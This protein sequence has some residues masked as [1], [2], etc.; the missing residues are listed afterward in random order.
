MMRSLENDILELKRFHLESNILKDTLNTCV[1]RSILPS[2]PNEKFVHFLVKLELLNPGWG[3]TTDV[4]RSRDNIQTLVKHLVNVLESQ[5]LLPVIALKMQFYYG[6]S[7]QHLDSSIS[8]N[9]ERMAVL[10]RP[11]RNDI[12]SVSAR[13]AFYNPDLFD[14]K[15]ISYAVLLTGIGNPQESNVYCEALRVWRSVMDEK[16]FASFLQ[17]DKEERDQ[18][19]EEISYLICGIRLYNWHSGKSEGH[20]IRDYGSLITELIEILRRN[21]ENTI[22]GTLKWIDVLAVTVD[23][24]F[25]VSCIGDEV[26]LTL[27]LS[28]DIKKKDVYA[29]RDLLLIF[30]QHL[31][32]LRKMLHLLKTKERQADQ[33]ARTFQEKLNH[34]DGMIVGRYAVVASET[35][36]VFIDLAKSW[37]DLKNR[38]IPLLKLEEVMNVLGALRKKAVS[39]TNKALEKIHDITSIPASMISV[40]NNDYETEEEETEVLC[41]RPRLKSMNL[42]VVIRPRSSLDRDKVEYN[43][44]CGFTLVQTEGALVFGDQSLGLANHLGKWYAFSSPEACLAFSRNPSRYI[45]G[46]IKL[47]RTSPHL[48]EIL[49]MRDYLEVI[50]D[51]EVIVEEKP[52]RTKTLTTGTQCE[53][54]YEK[55]VEPSIDEEYDWNIWSMKLKA[56]QLGH[57]MNCGTHASQ[58]QQTHTVTATRIQ[59][60]RFKHKN[61]QTKKDNYAN[62]PKPARYIAGLRAPDPKKWFDIDLTRP[63]KE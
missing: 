34:L 38:I 14:R 60:D 61:L 29:F 46:V 13:E 45:N 40:A 43:G 53:D 26:K 1:E 44:Y 42:D 19:L 48:I 25:V 16:E 5:H 8:S 4:M 6:C 2:Q 39:Y 22:C 49:D 9:D 17:K 58:S 30:R 51:V 35:F 63:V 37:M 28:M 27:E 33:M 23:R 52:I 41:Q 59:T 21:L 24:F 50:R 15:I 3:I 10:L 31:M 32:Y 12:L 55:I 36:P 57:L 11:L 20:G 7:M 54:E 18:V 62:T 56:L 47:V